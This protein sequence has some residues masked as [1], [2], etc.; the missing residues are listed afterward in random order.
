MGASLLGALV[1]CVAAAVVLDE[2]DVLVAAPKVKVFEL[3]KEPEV[4]VVLRVM[5]LFELPVLEEVEAVIGA[6]ALPEVMVLV[7]AMLEEP[8]PPDTVNSPE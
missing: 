6:V 5:L 8:V 4:V 1:L 3:V 7:P 2:R